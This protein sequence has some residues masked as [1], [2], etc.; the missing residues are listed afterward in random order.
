MQILVIFG[1][2]ATAALIATFGYW[3]GISDRFDAY[4][5]VASVIEYLMYAIAIACI[6]AATFEIK[7]IMDGGDAQPRKQVRPRRVRQTRANRLSINREQ[8]RT[9]WP[10]YDSQGRP[11][12]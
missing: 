1:M 9:D 3:M 7:K 8:S 10:G 5:P 12:K 11:R 2:G 4:G 6:V